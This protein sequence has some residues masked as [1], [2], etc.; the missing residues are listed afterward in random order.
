MEDKHKSTKDLYDEFM[1]LF[2]KIASKCRETKEWV[3]MNQAGRAMSKALHE[4]RVNGFSEPVA[5]KGEITN[6]KS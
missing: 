1:S 2:E 4:Q 6:D 3:E 5:Q